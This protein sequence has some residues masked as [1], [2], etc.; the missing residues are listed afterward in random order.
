MQILWLK[1]W[2]IWEE[3]PGIK[4]SSNKS[5]KILLIVPRWENPVG[6]SALSAMIVSIDSISLQLKKLIT[7]YNMRL[8]LEI[9]SPIAVMNH[10]LFDGIDETPSVN[11]K[12]WKNMEQIYLSKLC[13][14]RLVTNYFILSNVDFSDSEYSQMRE[15]YNGASSSYVRPVSRNYFEADWY[16]LFSGCPFV[17]R[18][19]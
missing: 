13:L 12:Y 10:V 11:V 2:Q 1:I 6:T 14:E 7:D 18:Y 9:S 5:T 19:F 16:D 3:N 8:N 17:S 4:V 15:E